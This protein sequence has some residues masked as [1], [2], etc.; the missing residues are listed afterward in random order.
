MLPNQ[1]SNESVPTLN[2]LLYGFQQSRLLFN[3]IIKSSGLYGEVLQEI[4]VC[5]ITV[6]LVYIFIPEGDV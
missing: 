2:Q 1:L 4:K 6:E 5:T 3:E